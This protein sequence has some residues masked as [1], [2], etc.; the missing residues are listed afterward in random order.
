MGYNKNKDNIYIFSYK[1]NKNVNID[2]IIESLMF[3][4]LNDT[5]EIY[6]NKETMYVYNSSIY[7]QN[8]K[9]NSLNISNDYSIKYIN[10]DDDDVFL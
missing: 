3:F 6:G 4:S 7:Q 5:I 9:F 2:E 1:L 10:N 8:F